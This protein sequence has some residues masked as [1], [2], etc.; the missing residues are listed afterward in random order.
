MSSS[1]HQS[2]LVLNRDFDH[3]DALLENDDE[4]EHITIDEVFSDH[5]GE[6]GRQQIWLFCIISLAWTPAAFV[7]L[8]MAFFGA[9]SLYRMK[10]FVVFAVCSSCGALW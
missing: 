3:D 4:L 2:S 7:V 8:D 6:F 1:L 5:I 10:T 9:H